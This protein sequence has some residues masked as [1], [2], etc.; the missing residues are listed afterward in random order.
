[1]RKISRVINLLPCQN[2]D[3]FPT[4]HKGSDAESL[5][6]NW[7]VAWHPQLIAATQS[8]PLWCSTSQTA[9]ED[10]SSNSQ[11]SACA[12]DDFHD[13]HDVDHDDYHDEHSVGEEANHAPSNSE[14]QRTYDGSPFRLPPTPSQDDSKSDSHQFDAGLALWR[15][16]VILI[17]S[18]SI[19]SLGEGFAGEAA[20]V[21]AAMVAQRSNRREIISLLTQKLDLQT[22]P[23][24]DMWAREFYAIGYAWLQVQ[25]LTRQIRYSSNLNEN[26][27]NQALIAAAQAVINGHHSAAKNQI[28]ACYDT[29]LEEKSNYYPVKP[30]LVDIVLTAPTTTGQSLTKELQRQHPTNVLINGAIADFIASE[31]QPSAGLLRDRIANRTATIVGGNQAE[32]PDPLLARESVLNQLVLGRQSLLDVTGANVTVF[33]RHRAGLTHTLPEILDGLEYAGALHIALDRGVIPHSPS[34]TMRWS[35]PA[36]AELMA[37]TQTVVDASDPATFLDFSITF[38]R[39]LDSAHTATMLL[40]HWPDRA[41]W[42]FED[43]VQVAKHSSVL[44]EFQLVEDV[45]E[46]L[47]DP[48][49]EDQF[50]VDEY[51]PRYLA[52]AINKSTCAPLSSIQTYWSRYHRLVAALHLNTL[53]AIFSKINQLDCAK[54]CTQITERLKTLQAEIESATQSWS[55]PSDET[56]KRIE[57]IEKDLLTNLKSI[58]AAPNSN[59]ISNTDRNSKIKTGTVLINSLGFRRCLSAQTLRSPSNSDFHQSDR[60]WQLSAQNASP[61][62]NQQSWARVVEGFS[63]G[64]ISTDDLPNQKPKRIPEVLSDGQLQNEFFTALVDSNSGGLR[65]VQFYGKRGNKGGQRIVYH[66]AAHPKSSS[67]MICRE[68][69]SEATSKLSGQITTRGVIQMEDVEVAQFQQTFRLTRGQRWIELEIELTPKVKLPASAETWFASQL[70]WQDESCNLSS[71]HQQTR[72]ENIS[73]SISAPNF[74]EIGMSDYTLTLLTGGLPWHRRTARCKLDSLLIVGGEIATKFRFGIGF[75]ISHAS[76]AA[77]EFGSPNYQIDDFPLAVTPTS[78]VERSLLHLDC[79]NII[80][81]YCRPIFTGESLTAILIRFLETEGRSGQLN[82]SLALPIEQANQ[83]NFAGQNQKTLAIGVDKHTVA[84]DFSGHQ[85][86]QV[87]L[88]V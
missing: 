42:A 43:L 23:E 47:Y 32:L 67:K 70:A 78:T 41:H 33:L 11:S 44:G 35:G 54:Y 84:I 51:Q 34:E 79:K 19:D 62:Q 61:N 20:R 58:A 63:I 59:S 82:L 15:D 13:L 17:P 30:E 16:S 81:T 50:L 9:A 73:P 72:T 5:L 71:S 28:N 52:E 80:T 10:L 69:L 3:D 56:Q 57:E 7:T 49:Y 12:D 45:F 46:Q 88:Q 83:Q 21:A 66:D 4:F 27:F 85:F 8:R 87:E 1:M 39:Q 38:G 53:I 26:R 24:I 14:A 31:K 36:G 75:E 64:R 29:L 74:V 6:A 55:R 18:V 60:P 68:I 65:S 86:F 2:L 37:K 22:S 76:R 77:I 25:L 48:G 40:I